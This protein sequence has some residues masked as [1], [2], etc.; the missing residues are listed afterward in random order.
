MSCI[1]FGYQQSAVSYHEN[2]DRLYSC[3]WLIV[4]SQLTPVSI[5]EEQEVPE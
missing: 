5:M 1:E 2:N 4:A 3:R